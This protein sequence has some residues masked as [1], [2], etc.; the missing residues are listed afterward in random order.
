MDT[1]RE[2]V[3]YASEPP[4]RRPYFANAAAWLAAVQVLWWWPAAF[5]TVGAL[6]DN[7]WVQ[8]PLAE[9]LG[10]IFVGLPSVAA[11]PCAALA[12]RRGSPASGTVPAIISL[13]ASTGWL[14]WLGI[15]AVHD[16]RYPSPTPCL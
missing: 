10:A 14:A 3:E 15:A 13:I 11:L 16:L 8:N 7:G 2:V 4:S 12:L 1:R 5:F 9:A 6:C